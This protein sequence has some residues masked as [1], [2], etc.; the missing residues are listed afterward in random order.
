M[1][2]DSPKYLPGYWRGEADGCELHHCPFIWNPT[3][4]TYALIVMA[5]R[6]SMTN[7]C[8]SDSSNHP[9][10]RSKSC[11]ARPSIRGQATACAV[12]GYVCE[13]LLKP[14][15]RARLKESTRLGSTRLVQHLHLPPGLAESRARG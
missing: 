11:A 8:G 2:N 6:N 12:D 7:M 5:P 13:G 3:S 9:W 1:L 14:H 10:I 4:S 15:L